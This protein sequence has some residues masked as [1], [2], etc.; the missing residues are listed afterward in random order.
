MATV[1]YFDTKDLMGL[2]DPRRCGNY[3]NEP[4]LL[5]EDIESFLRDSGQLEWANEYSTKEVN[6]ASDFSQLIKAFIKNKGLDYI[7][8]NGDSAKYKKCKMHPRKYVNINLIAND[9]H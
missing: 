3:F 4:N 7:L 1:F 2:F 8:C 6:W 9:L 5:Q